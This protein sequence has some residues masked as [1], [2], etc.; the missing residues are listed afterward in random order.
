MRNGA[1]HGLDFFWVDGVAD[2]VIGGKWFMLVV[3]KILW[4]GSFVWESCGSDV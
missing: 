2:P 1:G 4:C 3:D